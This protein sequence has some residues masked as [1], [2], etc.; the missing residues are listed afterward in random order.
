MKLHA[1]NISLGNDRGVLHTVFSLTNHNI[2]VTRF[3]VER[4]NEITER[5]ISDTGKQSMLLLLANAIPTD[6]RHDLV[7]FEPAHA[8][9]QQ[10]KPVRGPKLFG[11]IKQHLHT[12]ANP[13][14]RRPSRRS[15]AHQR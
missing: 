2:R 5:P 12:D 10:P 15:F 4:M 3:A 9:T 13:E 11:N 6:L 8:P 14:Q 7:Y 1:A